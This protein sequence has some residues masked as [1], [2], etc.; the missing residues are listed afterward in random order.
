VAAFYRQKSNQKEGAYHRKN[1]T[2]TNASGGGAG[3]TRFILQQNRR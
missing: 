1:P 2:L 3:G